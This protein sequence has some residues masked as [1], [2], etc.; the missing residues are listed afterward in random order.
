MGRKGGSSRVLVRLVRTAAAPI[1][2]LLSRADLWDRDLTKL[3]LKNQPTKR[4]QQ[5]EDSHGKRSRTTA[6]AEPEEEVQASPSAAA[7]LGDP[8]QTQVGHNERSDSDDE[9][10][11][12]ASKEPDVALTSDHEREADL[13]PVP[14]DDSENEDDVFGLE[15]DAQEARREHPAIPSKPTRIIFESSD[16]EDS[17]P[18]RAPVK[19]P[20][21]GQDLPR[22]GSDEEHD[23]LPV[24]TVSSTTDPLSSAIRESES[25]EEE[26]E[27]QE[28]EKDDAEEPEESEEESSAARGAIEGEL[29]FTF[30]E[31][32]EDSGGEQNP[33]EE[34]DGGSDDDDEG[35]AVLTR[36]KVLSRSITTKPTKIVFGSDDEDS[37]QVVEIQHLP[38]KDYADIYLD[39][40][41]DPEGLGLPGGF[42][43]KHARMLRKAERQRRKRRNRNREPREQFEKEDATEPQPLAE[44]KGDKS[45]DLELQSHSQLGDT[46]AQAVIQGELP[47]DAANAPPTCSVSSAQELRD[48]EVTPSAWAGIA[49]PNDP[50]WLAYWQQVYAFLVSNQSSSAEV[51][52]EAVS[53]P[54]TQ[55]C[56]ELPSG[57][58]TAESVSGES[59]AKDSEM[60]L[61]QEAVASNEPHAMQWSAFLNDNYQYYFAQFWEERWRCL[62]ESAEPRQV[63]PGA[64]QV[65]TAGMLRIED[66]YATLGFK[67]SPLSESVSFKAIRKHYSEEEDNLNADPEIADSESRLSPFEGVA[68]ASE[69]LEGDAAEDHPTLSVANHDQQDSSSTPVAAD[70][71]ITSSSASRQHKYWLQ[72]YRLFSRFDQGI[73]LDEESWYSVT[74]ERLAEHIAERC[75]CDVIVDAFCGAGGNSI[76]FAFSCERVIAIDIDPKKIE[77]A[78]H[79]AR[80]YGVEDRIEFIIGDFLEVAPRLKADVV[81]LSPPWGGPSYTNKRVFDLSTMNPS[82]RNIFNAAKT[83]SQNLVLFLPK[84][85]DVEQLVDLASH[86]TKCEIEQSLLNRKCKALTVYF[87]PYLCQ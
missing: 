13:R 29:D 37:P 20:L 57:F 43:S 18:T 77:M 5:Q 64:R 48:A 56:V 55:P 84:N 81:F 24:T 49:D 69:H 54:P 51:A 7:E 32:P 21:R 35:D 66:I 39:S 87:G 78:R 73:Q 22:K 6:E 11:E 59:S 86:R 75:R 14:E 61:D 63:A 8:E 60:P 23:E 68:E 70:A 76:Q 3:H 9:A 46:S 26:Q 16:E 83:I 67:F 65:A 50:D 53:A 62:Q 12:T 42:T 36:E 31:V 1:S 15:A 72:R 71:S 28:V 52:V 58:S 2:L 17:T 74:P 85:T 79:N 82:G 10:P 47:D 80:I 40:D 4:K 45:I 27:E 34:V 25:E 38:A 41:D 44:A 33:E 30:F 19:S